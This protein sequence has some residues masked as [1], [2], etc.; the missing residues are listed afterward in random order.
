MWS[1]KVICIYPRKGKGRD[2]DCLECCALNIA[3]LQFS[4]QSRAG[5]SNRICRDIGLEIIL[6]YL[7]DRMI[8]VQTSGE[9]KGK[10]PENISQH[11][12]N[13]INRV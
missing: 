12:K 11:F 7:C 4:L 10:I 5:E 9:K 8:V 6:K 2:L 13:I 1:F 3:S